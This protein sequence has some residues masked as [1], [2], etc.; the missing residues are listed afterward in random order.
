M[1]LMMMSQ[2]SRVQSIPLRRR[3]PAHVSDDVKLK[4]VGAGVVAAAVV[5]ATADVS[6]RCQGLSSC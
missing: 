1:V 3:P 4:G 2:S 5:V 6:G